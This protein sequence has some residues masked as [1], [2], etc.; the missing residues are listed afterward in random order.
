MRGQAV[1]SASVADIERLLYL[2]RLMAVDHHLDFIQYTW[3]NQT[4]PYVVGL[5]TR[6]ICAVIDEAIERFRHQQSTFLRI[7]VP[8]RHGKSE[9]ISRKLPAHFLGLFPDSK[10]ILCGH[11]AELT[12]GYSRT[13]RNLISTAAYRDLFPEVAVAPDSG[14]GAHWRIYHHEGECFASGLLG[15]LSGQGYQLGILDDYCRNRADAESETM[16]EKMWAAFTN[17]FLTRRAPVSI[18]IVLAT[19]WHVDDIIG[20]IERKINPKS[21]EY[22]KDF[23]AFKVVTF[24]AMD[25]DVI[26]NGQEVK[27]KYLFPER[28]SAEWYEQQ[29]ASLGA[30]SAAALLQCNPVMRGGGL[31]DTSH[32]AIHDKEVDFPKVQYC[33]VWDLAH[34][35]RQTM[36]GDPDYTSGTLLAF[37]K[38]NGVY[39]LW[40]KDVARIR[41]EAPERDNFI[42]SVTEKDGA[43]V[44]IAVE[45]SLDSK[46]AA[47][48]LSVALKGRRVVK[49]VNIKDDKI[50]RAGYIEPI[51]EAGNVHIL[52]GEWNREWLEEVGDFPGGRHDDQVD[53]LT[54]GYYHKCINGKTLVKGKV[55][56]V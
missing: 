16:R 54:A 19:P 48:R 7:A 38:T 40:I 37:T 42:M 45:N 2:R 10:V 25:G 31:I 49:S 30:Y 24:P 35:A 39:S 1:I 43:S 36:K 14:A 15:S 22:D 51:F 52:R 23:P 3:T 41:A 4:E 8:F 9:I 34:T 32:I 17:D 33:R 55:Y 47:A 29:R 5:H 20:R 13:S 56:G 21:E 12:E 28:F 26:V 53:N 6:K 50:T 11:T 27:Y 46:D 18:T 44:S